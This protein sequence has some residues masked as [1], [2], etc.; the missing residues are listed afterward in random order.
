MLT[1][2]AGAGAD[3][4]VVWQLVLQ[5]FDE[6]G[7]QAMDAA[8]E[9]RRQHEEADRRRR[10]RQERDR[11]QELQPPPQPAQVTEVTDEEAERIQR[12]LDEKVGTGTSLGQSGCLCVMGRGTFAERLG[13]EELETRLF[14]NYSLRYSVI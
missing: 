12:E 6:H 2:T 8:A 13:N 1:L 14:V 9:K 11:Q 3:S 10:E 5:K 7:R 4:R